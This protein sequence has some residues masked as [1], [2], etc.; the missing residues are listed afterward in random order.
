M[1]FFLDLRTSSGEHGIDA[2]AILPFPPMHQLDRV[3]LLG[4]YKTPRFKYGAV[5]TRAIRGKVKIVALTDGR[6]PWPKC[7]MR[8]G[9]RA[10]ILYGALA[11]AVRRESVEAIK[12]LVWRGKRYGLALAE[13]SPADKPI[14]RSAV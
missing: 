11:E 2:E 9:S 6:I 1:D 3:K 8:N 10:I 14:S 12:I 5:V 4:R 13:G 7:Q